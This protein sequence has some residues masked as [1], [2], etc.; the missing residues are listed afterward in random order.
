VLL[1]SAAELGLTTSERRSYLELL[2]AAQG[3]TGG[4][5]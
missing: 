2:L 1:R 3:A 4:R 5:R